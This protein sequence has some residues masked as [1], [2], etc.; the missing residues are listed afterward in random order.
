MKLSLLNPNLSIH[1]YCSDLENLISWADDIEAAAFR[2]FKE[3]SAYLGM[4][5][6]FGDAQRWR[7]KF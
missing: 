1:G 7:K 4:D 2:V 3:F 6:E 5:F